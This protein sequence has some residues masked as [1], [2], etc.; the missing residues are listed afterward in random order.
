[1]LKNTYIKLV[2]LCLGGGKYPRVTM[3]DCHKNSNALNRNDTEG[4]TDQSPGQR[5]GEKR[6]VQEIPRQCMLS[7]LTS[8]FEGFIAK[9]N[10]DYRGVDRVFA[11]NH[12]IKSVPLTRF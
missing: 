11:G 2:I 9:S 5:P 7:T 6:G 12:R 8:G 10:K 1:M 4:V 3:M